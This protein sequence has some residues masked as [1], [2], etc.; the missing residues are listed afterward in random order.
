MLNKMGCIS[1]ITLL[2][3][4]V[5]CG[6]ALASTVPPAQDK[7]L[8][9]KAEITDTEVLFTRAINNVS[10]V[11][12]R[13]E[14]TAQLINTGSSTKL[15]L[16]VY[17]TTQ[18]LKEV[19][20]DDGTVVST[21][22]ITVFA[23][24]PN[25]KWDVAGGLRAYSTV[26]YDIVKDQYQ[27]QFYDLYKVTGGWDRYDSTYSLSGREVSVG[28]VGGGMGGGVTTNQ[29]MY[30]YP[31]SNSFT[32]YTPSSWIPANPLNIG[33]AGCISYIKIDRFGEKWDLTLNNN[34]PRIL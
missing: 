9:E 18:L 10:D 16:E 26:Y 32:Y 21:C 17:S 34:L 30:K 31:S 20:K 23:T 28:L 19:K 7:I 3:M 29:V 11:Q 33:G 12:I 25:D 6:T 27:M 14:A 4:V 13:P 5:F 15:D 1:A 22:A 2:L 24:L 8:I